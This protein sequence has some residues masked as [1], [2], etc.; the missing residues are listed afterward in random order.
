V[1]LAAGIALMR[2][3]LI[4]GITERWPHGRADA[5][6]GVFCRGARRL[7]RRLDP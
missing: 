5:H 6:D 1:V 7:D 4:T 3:R 2:A